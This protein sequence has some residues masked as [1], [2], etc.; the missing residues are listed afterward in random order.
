MAWVESIGY[1]QIV[2]TLALIVSVGGWLHQRRAL[3]RAFD[4]ETPVVHI[5][6]VEDDVPAGWARLRVKL[7]SRSG[8]SFTMTT[9]RIDKPSGGR[10]VNYWDAGDY[11]ATDGRWTIDF[12]TAQSQSAKAID[13]GLS[14][15]HKGQDKVYSAGRFQMGS[16]DTHDSDVLVLLPDASIRSAAWRARPK[17]Q[18]ISVTSVLISNS[19]RRKRLA[20]N[21]RLDIQ[22]PATTAITQ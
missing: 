14:V 7:R 20:I 6:Q 1:A 9:L 13:P 21:S 11:S 16:G 17:L 19:Q 2:S 18:T 4:S 10:L 8:E 12:E 15:A 5:V 22:M 3:K